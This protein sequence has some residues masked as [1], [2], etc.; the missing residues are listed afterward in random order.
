M[1]SPTPPTCEAQVR[2]LTALEPSDVTD[3]WREVVDRAGKDRITAKLVD[4]VVKWW[5]TPGDEQ[6]DII[7]SVV[8]QRESQASAAL[9]GD[10]VQCG[11]GEPSDTELSGGSDGFGEVAPE[12][13]LILADN[14]KPAAA[15]QA[16]LRRRCREDGQVVA[17]RRTRR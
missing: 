2:P 6:R 10:T 4:E 15:P 14:P 9:D 1:A 5:K 12:D 7:S 17:C 8:S 13:D 11:S 3:V 16:K